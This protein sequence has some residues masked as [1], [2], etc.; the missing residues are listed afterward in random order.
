MRPPEFTGGKGKTLNSV[1]GSTIG[2]NEAAGIHRRKD[3][4]SYFICTSDFACFNEAAGIHRRK[5]MRE[6]PQI[7]SNLCFNEAAGIHRR[8]VVIVHPCY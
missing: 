3:G 7:T 1:Y 2:F 5:D 8:K 4:R 6:I